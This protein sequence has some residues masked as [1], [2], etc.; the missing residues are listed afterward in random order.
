MLY[1]YQGVL[2]DVWGNKKPLENEQLN[3]SFCEM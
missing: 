1:S 2:A 3:I